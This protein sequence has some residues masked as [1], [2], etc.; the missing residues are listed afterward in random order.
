MADKNIEQM[1]DFL[2]INPDEEIFNE[3]SELLERQNIPGFDEFAILLALPDEQFEVLSELVLTELEKAFMNPQDRLLLQ[4][5]MRQDGKTGLDFINIQ[6]SL[7][8]EIEDKIKDKVSPIKLDFLKRTM[9]MITNV[10][11]QIDG[12]AGEIVSIPIELSEGAIAPTYANESD[13]AMDIYALEDYTIN[14]G[15]T[16]LIKTGIKVAIPRGYALLIQPR[17]GQSLKTKLR[18]ANTPGLIDSG[19]RD[20]IGI[21]MEN[22]ESP[23][24]DIEYTFNKNGNIVINS[25]LHGKPY[26][27]EK[28]QRIAQMRLVH[29]PAVNWTPVNNI[30]EIEGNRGGGFGSSGK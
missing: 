4:K 6:Q 13:G 27:V 19:Y 15:E 24:A 26:V 1:Q 2:T 30:L 25:I 5:A 3:I 8:D 12:M 10:F 7:I 9:T 14:P 17:S 16:K 22:I 20:E 11:S 18:V 29:V 28:G 21:I 23:I